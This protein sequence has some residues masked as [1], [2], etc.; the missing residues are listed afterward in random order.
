MWMLSNRETRMIGESGCSCDR[1]YLGAV[2]KR[3]MDSSATRACCRTASLMHGCC[4]IYS[5]PSLL[6][7][8]LCLY[9]SCHQHAES[10]VLPAT[11]QA[12]ERCINRI[13][14]QHKA[15]RTCICDSNQAICE[16]G[17][18][19]ACK[20]AVTGWVLGPRCAGV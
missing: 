16:P 15:H 5:F 13:E 17:L 2:P 1:C 7:A 6:Y 20:C 12:R 3:G 14:A 10:T 9:K 18:I 4:S 8:K 19:A 11:A